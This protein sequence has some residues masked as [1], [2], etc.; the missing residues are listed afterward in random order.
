[1]QL[2]PAVIAHTHT[3]TVCIHLHRNVLSAPLWRIYQL[4]VYQI[5]IKRW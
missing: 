5:E 1:M 3:H 2:T 4:I